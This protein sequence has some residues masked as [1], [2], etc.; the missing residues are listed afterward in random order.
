[1]IINN[2]TLD[3]FKRDV[4]EALRGVAAK[5]GVTIKGGGATYSSDSFSLPLK[6]ANVGVDGIKTETKKAIDTID[7]FR[8]IYNKRF[9][10]G[11]HT[12]KVIGYNWGKKYPIECLRDDDKIFNYMP[13]IVNSMEFFD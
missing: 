3:E 13:T 4:E 12:Y 8:D 11:R 2:N 7:W 6:V 10:D 1:M 9:R 5:Y